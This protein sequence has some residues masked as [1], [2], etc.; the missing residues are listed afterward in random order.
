MFFPLGQ[1]KLNVLQKNEHKHSKN[2]TIYI[3][4]GLHKLVHAECLHI[5]LWLTLVKH[6]LPPMCRLHLTTHACLNIDVCYQVY[7]IYEGVIYIGA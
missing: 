1:S 6:I 5:H 2:L 7:N 3:L 4:M